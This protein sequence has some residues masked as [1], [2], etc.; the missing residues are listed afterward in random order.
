MGALEV[1]AV[2]A[3]FSEAAL[4]LLRSEGVLGA[5]GEAKLELS[6]AMTA[7]ERVGLLGTFGNPSAG[8]HPTAAV[9][10][11]AAAHAA[12]L[13]AAQVRAA[14]LRARATASARVLGMCELS[15]A[16]VLRFLTLTLTL[17]LTVTRTR[18]RTLTLPLPLLLLLP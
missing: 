9:P 2:L 5:E 8:L 6:N 12:S 13:S 18:T 11:A 4:G 7:L 17:A 15:S 16:E 1:G 3:E 10:S 14:F